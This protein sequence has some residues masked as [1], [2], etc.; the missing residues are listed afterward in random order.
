M[1]QGIRTLNSYMNNY[2]TLTTNSSSAAWA[3]G[4]ATWNTTYFNIGTPTAITVTLP[5]YSLSTTA[6]SST[7]SAEIRIVF[8]AGSSTTL[9][10]TKASGQSTCGVGDLPSFTANKYYEVSISPLSATVMAV[11]CKEW[12]VDS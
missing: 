1:A 12:G 3:I 9:T 6:S 7:G 4:T 2:P 8:K 11:A 10:I 5:T